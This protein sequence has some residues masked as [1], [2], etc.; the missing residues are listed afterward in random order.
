VRLD[1]ALVE[2]G[3][4]PSRSRARDL[5]LRGM[6]AVDGQITTKPSLTIGAEHTLQLTDDARVFVSRG[7][8]KLATALD[9]FGFE[10][11]GRLCLDVGASTGGFTE[12]LLARGATCVIAV[13]VGHGQLH[14]RIAADARVRSLEGTDA[15]ALDR[16]LVPD[17]VEAI[18]V[19]VSF[20]SVTKALGAALGLASLGAWLVVLVKPQFE[21]GRGNVGRGGIVRD[22]AAHKGA[23]ET[24]AAWLRD[25]GWTVS[26][27]IPSP[28]T[29]G[30]GNREFLIGARLG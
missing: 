15:R 7:A 5:V 21:V 28:I 2:R 24:V 26:G 29:G 1:Q 27:T 20:I 30:D 9:H 16:G 13:D 3:L 6:V 12:I 23:V 4:V 19:D 18:V 25:A 14:P 17:P 22:A 11:S 8:E 10:A